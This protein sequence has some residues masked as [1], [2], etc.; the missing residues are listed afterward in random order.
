MTWLMWLMWSMGA[1]GL[2]GT[3]R[4]FAYTCDVK[5]PW[6]VALVGVLLLVQVAC[7][8]CSIML[9]FKAKKIN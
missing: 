6:A 2:A 4:S 3:V 5:P 8:T 7:G 9:W 1:M